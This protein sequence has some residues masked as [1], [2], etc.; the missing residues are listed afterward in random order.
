M[1]QSYLIKTERKNLILNFNSFNSTSGNLNLTIE[2]KFDKY[3]YKNECGVVLGYSKFNILNCLHFELFDNH[4]NL[5][6]TVTYYLKNVKKKKIF[7][8]DNIAEKLYTNKLPELNQIT[9][10]LVYK[11]NH[12]VYRMSQIN[13]QLADANDNV[14]LEFGKIDK[15]SYRLEYNSKHFTHVEAISVAITRFHYI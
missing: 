14:I 2:R 7:Y 8:Y 9:N 6:N 10:K 1:N 3:L 11:F 13:F 15:S 4:N 5:I 12:G